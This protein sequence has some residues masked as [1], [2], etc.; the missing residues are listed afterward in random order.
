M[1]QSANKIAEHSQIALS[2][3]SFRLVWL[4]LPSCRNV[5]YREENN[6]FDSQWCRGFPG[7]RRPS[8]H[9]HRTRRT[10][11][12]VGRLAMYNSRFQYC[13]KH[14]RNQISKSRCLLIV[15]LFSY[16]IW[17][18]MPRMGPI[19]RT[20]RTIIFRSSFRNAQPMVCKSGL[21]IVRCPAPKNATG[22]TTASKNCNRS[23]TRTVWSHQT[24]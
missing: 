22:V 6:K 15:L 14:L 23:V 18:I 12:L 3:N 11:R 13:L 10:H 16:Q 9:Q 7:R 1:S 8:G 5:L 2:R 24:C 19:N 17:K 20:R 4:H 21:W